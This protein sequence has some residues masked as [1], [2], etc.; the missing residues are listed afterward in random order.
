MAGTNKGTFYLKIF[1]KRCISKYRRRKSLI[2]SHQE[3]NNIYDRWLVGFYHS[4]LFI[5]LIG[6]PLTGSNSSSLCVACLRLMVDSE[7]LT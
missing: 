4:N 5:V 7:Q 1:L 3:T 2:I 6:I